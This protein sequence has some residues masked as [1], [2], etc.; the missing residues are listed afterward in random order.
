MKI[1]GFSMLL[2]NMDFNPCKKLMKSI[3]LKTTTLSFILK[4][5]LVTLQIQSYLLLIVQF[6]VK[7]SFLLIS[8]TSETKGW[9]IFYYF[10]DLIYQLI[11]V[12]NQRITSWNYKSSWSSTIRI[13]EKICKSLTDREKQANRRAR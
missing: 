6:A 2:E 4:N 8:G 11:L 7:E 3:C 12:R 1:R 9:L 5:L 13:P 10:S